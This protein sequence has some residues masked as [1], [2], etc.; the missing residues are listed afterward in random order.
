M[1]RF[2]PDALRALAAIALALALAT[3]ASALDFPSAMKQSQAAIGRVVDDY[4]FTSA[5]GRRVRMS[6][7]RGKPLVES[8]VYTGCSQICP[9]TT[10]F[11]A[12]AVKEAN[13]ALGTDAFNVATIGFNLPFDNPAA[14]RQFARQQGV[15]DPR[16]TF[17]SPDAGSVEALTR[18]FGFVYAPSPG[19]F[20]HIAQVTIVDANG[21]IA[22]QIYGDTFDPQLLVGAVREVTTGAPGALQDLSGLLDR[23]RVLCSVYDPATGRYRLDYSLFIEIFAGLTVLGAIGYYLGGEWR[24]QRRARRDHVAA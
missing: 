24:R 2:S 12:T 21:R 9:A 6:D 22:R 13:R 23:V 10:R 19:G 16:W 3:P 1:R 8:F 20:D 11:L 7:F 15:D 5:D 17:L 4:A 14:M 18:A